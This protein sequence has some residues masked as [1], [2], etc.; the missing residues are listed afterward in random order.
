MRFEANARIN[1]NLLDNGDTQVWR[2]GPGDWRIQTTDPDKIRRLAGLTRVRLLGQAVT[3]GR[4]AIFGLSGRKINTNTVGRVLAGNADGKSGA[5]RTI[6]S[7]NSSAET[8][9]SA[10]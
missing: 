2:V 5:M 6:S 9:E 4:L 1:R 3:G 10:A 7:P 8:S